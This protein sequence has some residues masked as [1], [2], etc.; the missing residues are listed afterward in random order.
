MGYV[1]YMAF[2]FCQS[3]VLLVTFVFA[4]VLYIRLALFLKPDSNATTSG[5]QDDD[6]FEDLN[7]SAFE[8]KR[9]V[10][11]KNFQPQYLRLNVVLLYLLLVL[12]IRTVTYFCLRLTS[13][14]KI[15]EWQIIKPSVFYVTYVTDFMILVGVLNFIASSTPLKE[16]YQTASSIVPDTAGNNADQPG[17]EASDGSVDGDAIL[18]A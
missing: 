4:W 13:Y 2:F 15:F 5:S 14:E 6:E 16:K 10:I 12:T 3:L 18:F 17:S 1:A 11:R 9:D 8:R 7:K